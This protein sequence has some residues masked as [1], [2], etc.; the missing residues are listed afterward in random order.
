MTVSR[1]FLAASFLFSCIAQSS[2]PLNKRTE[3]FNLLE[4]KICSSTDAINDIDH[5]FFWK[6]GLYD[7][8]VSISTYFP[9]KKGALSRENLMLAAKIQ[10]AK[11]RHRSFAMGKCGH[12]FAWV[13]SFP[14]PVKLDSKRL[15]KT[16]ADKCDSFKVHTTPTKENLTINNLLSSKHLYSFASI[17]CKPKVPS[18][19]GPQEWFLIKGD[20]SDQLAVKLLR[21]SEFPSL[22]LMPVFSSIIK[23][24]RLSNLPPLTIHRSLDG[25]AKRLGRSGSIL[26]N[27]KRLRILSKITKESV[28]SLRKVAETR[29]IAKNMTEFIELVLASPA[30]RNMLLNP[31]ANHIGVEVKKLNGSFLI[32]I[33]TGEID[34]V[35]TSSNPLDQQVR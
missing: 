32:V 1:I 29:V 23:M 25:I 3:L 4:N 7:S 10:M 13:A 11:E 33:I 5:H 30:H 18:W 8:Q 9:E 12:R 34:E 20:L 22:D 17:M 31:A 28:G 19:Q 16:L 27:S 15:V 6:H 35:K 2:V 21:E 26:H 14:S 24:R